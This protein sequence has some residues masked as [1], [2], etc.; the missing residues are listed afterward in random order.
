MW[1]VQPGGACSCIIAIVTSLADDVTNVQVQDHQE[2]VMCE[3]NCDKWFHRE[4]LR[5]C[6]S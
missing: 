5:A 6:T 4:C 2:G 1:R 3:D